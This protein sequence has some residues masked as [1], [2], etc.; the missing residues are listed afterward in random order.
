MHSVGISLKQWPEFY[1]HAQTK[2][3]DNVDSALLIF[4]VCVAVRNKQ[5]ISSLRTCIEFYLSINFYQV[6]IPLFENIT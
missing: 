1:A 5:H 3:C 6:A 4:V 2:H